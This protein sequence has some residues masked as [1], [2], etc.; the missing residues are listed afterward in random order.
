M[1]KP[2]QDKPAWRAPIVQ[3]FKPKLPPQGL[4]GDFTAVSPGPLTGPGQQRI[5]ILIQ[6]QDLRGGLHV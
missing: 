5:Q 3:L 2:M 4:P 1:A 6:S